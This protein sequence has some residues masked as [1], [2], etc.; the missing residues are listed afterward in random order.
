MTKTRLVLGLALALCFATV[1]VAQ[2]DAPAK[3][4]G[5]DKAKSQA[6]KSTT[7][8]MMKAFTPAKLTEEQKE[9]ATAIIEKHI[10]SLL[11][12]RKVAADMLTKDQKKTKREAAK[13]AKEDGLKG[14]KAA[15]AVDV[16]LGLPEEKLA[17]YKA[18]LKKPQEVT[19]K[20]KAAITELLT[21]DQKAAMPKR[22]K[23]KKAKGGKKKKDKAESDGNLQ[24]VALKLPNMT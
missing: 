19:A 4:K 13:K 2:D 12:A 16:A 1:G 5:A 20:I 3:K 24:T 8:Q 11:A 9:K 6:L 15:E 22:G 10:D 21:D 23:G 17:E 18:A 14:P 7:A